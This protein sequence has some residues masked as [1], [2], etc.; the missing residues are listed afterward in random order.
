[1]KK[2]IYGVAF[3]NVILFAVFSLFLIGGPVAAEEE[4]P[5]L[6]DLYRVGE[7]LPPVEVTGLDGKMVNVPSLL[8]G[9]KNYVVFFNTSC[10]NCIGEM[11]AFADHYETATKKGIDIVA[12]CID[13]AGVETAK[14]FQKRGK[15]PFPIVSDKEFEL[16]KRMGIYSTPATV[17]LDE[18]KKITKIWTGYNNDLHAALLKELQ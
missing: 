9:K 6:K 15:Y 3:V 12:V 16:G 8:K 10:R 4:K 11:N 14:R 17:I 1:M 7:E 13:I 2:R 18:E 5:K